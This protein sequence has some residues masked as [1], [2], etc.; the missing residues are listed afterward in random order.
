MRRKFNVTLLTLLVLVSIFAT[1][2]PRTRVTGEVGVETSCPAGQRCTTKVSGK[3]TV[4]Y[5]RLNEFSQNENHF[6]IFDLPN[7]WTAVDVPASEVTVKIRDGNGQFVEQT[8]SLTRVDSTAIDPVDKDTTPVAYVYTDPTAVN[9]F[10]NSNSLMLNFDESEV[11][12][13]FRMSVMRAACQTPGGK[14][15]SHIRYQDGSGITYVQTLTFNYTA[16]ENV[17]SGCD[18]GELQIEL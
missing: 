1:G 13:S 15:P 5:P 17:Q 4:T 8:F 10:F 14:Y 18:E 6:G 9:N 7:Q 16:P 12:M 2:C 11:E 3:V